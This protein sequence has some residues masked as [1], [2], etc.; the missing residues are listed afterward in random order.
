MRQPRFAVFADFI[1]VYVRSG[2]G[3][4]APVKATSNENENIIKRFEKKLANSLNII[5]YMP[6]QAHIN[7][8]V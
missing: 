1:I 3:A 6:Y 4:I 2:S 7:R 8:E 5:V